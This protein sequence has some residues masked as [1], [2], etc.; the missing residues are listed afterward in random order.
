M[1]H[2]YNSSRKNISKIIWHCGHLSFGDTAR[3]HFCKCRDFHTIQ[4]ERYFLYY[5]AINVPKILYIACKKFGVIQVCINEALNMSEV[6]YNG[7][8]VLQIMKD[9][10]WVKQNHITAR[11]QL[12]AA[13][14]GGSEGWNI[15]V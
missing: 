1:P 14:S 11:M 4:W 15:Q 12:D 2:L 10:R 13:M 5:F 9:E 8:E 6:N 7:A 3:V